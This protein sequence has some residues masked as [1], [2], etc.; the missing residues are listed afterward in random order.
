MDLSC[1]FL[2]LSTELLIEI[3]SYLPATDLLSA[4]RTCR[5]L[6][7]VVT[8]TSYFRYILR[9]HMTGV[10]DFLP[11]DFSY[12]ERLELLQRYEQSWNDLN[13]NL[14]TECVAEFLFLDEFFLQGGYLIHKD[15][16]R[17][18]LAYGYTDLC[19]AV[20]GE[21]LDWVHISIDNGLDFILSTTA[22]AVDQDLMVAIRF[23][24]LSN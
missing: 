5:T 18:V 22:F 17:M 8:S 11:P 4:Q 10:G 6:R 21:G 7:A 23:G 15:F 14:F 13:L 12:P 3:L 9:T 20:Q 24:V 2:T 1:D 19:S 16:E